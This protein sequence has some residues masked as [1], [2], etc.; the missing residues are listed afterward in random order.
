[1]IYHIL[2]NPL[3]RNGKGADE[4]KAVSAKLNGEAV[5]TDITS[6]TSYPDYFGGIKEGDKLVIC[7]G[8]GTLN[9]FVNDC[10]ELPDCD[11]LYFATGSG[12]DFLTDIGHKYGDGP[13]K[14]NEYLT[15]LPTVTVNGKDRKFINGIGYGIDGFCCEIGDKKRIE[16]P[17]KDINYAS[18]A[19]KGMLYAFGPRKAKITVDGKEYAFP[20]TWLAPTMNGRMY[21]GGMIPTPHQQRISDDKKLSVLYFGGAGRLHTLILF[22]GIFSGEHLKHDK[23][24]KEFAGKE[25]SVE[26]NKP[27]ALQIDGETVLGV[28]EYT[29]RI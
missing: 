21:G 10:G 4:A 19:I 8:D 25:I 16:N 6:V 7:G 12:N 27:T 24:C 9:R 26:F 17:G 20:K 28:T 3:S 29:A 14:I 22:P 2:F 18:I 13:V 5:F 23:Y 11:I 15:D 1:M